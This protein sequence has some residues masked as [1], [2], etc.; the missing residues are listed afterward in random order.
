MTIS[1]SQD[2]KVHQKESL[3]TSNVLASEAHLIDRIGVFCSIDSL[4]TQYAQR[5]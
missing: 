3:P 2:D 4:L 5:S 1:I